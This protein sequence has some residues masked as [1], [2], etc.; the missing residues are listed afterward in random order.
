MF[1]LLCCARDTYKTGGLFLTWILTGN[2]EKYDQFRSKSWPSWKPD[3]T[4][5]LLFSR[6]IIYCLASA[7]H[8]PGERCFPGTI[9]PLIFHFKRWLITK[10]KRS[11]WEATI[12][13]VSSFAVLS[14][15]NCSIDR[16]LGGGVTWWCFRSRVNEGRTSKRDGPLFT[17]VLVWCDKVR[18]HVITYLEMWGT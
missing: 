13:F 7:T 5:H 4:G 17:V 12:R 8:I 2:I 6:R 15:G 16:R 3:C 10:N 14:R 1:R 11:H 9:L 18:I